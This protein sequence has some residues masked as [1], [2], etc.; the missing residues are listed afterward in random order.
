MKQTLSDSTSLVM[1]VRPSPSEFTVPENI[2]RRLLVAANSYRLDEA[3]EL[4]TEAARTDRGRSALAYKDVLPAVLQLSRLLSSSSSVHPHLIFSTLR[5]LRNLCAGEIVNQNSF[6]REN[7]VEVVSIASSYVDL[8]SNSD[9]SFVRVGLQVFGNVSLGGE[10]HRTAVWDWHF[11]AVFLDIARIHKVEVF[12]PLCMVIYNC[13]KGRH[14]RIRELSGVQGLPI[15]I[16]IVRTASTV[17][18]QED[19]FKLLLSIICFEESHFLSLFSE[20]RLVENAGNFKYGDN[21]FT[22]EQAF[23]L[24]TVAECL[25]KKMTEIS[26]SNEFANCVLGIL[27]VAVGVLDCVSKEKFGLP[28]GSAAIDVLGYSLTTLRDICARDEML[29]SEKDS[30]AGVIESLLSAGLV[31][32]ML[33]LLRNLEPPAI[34]KKSI[35]QVESCENRK[36]Y[37]SSNSLKVCPYKGFRRD[38]V[39]VIGNCLYRREHVQDEIRQNNGIP[40]LLQ[41]CVTDEDNPFLREWGIWMVRNLLAGNAENQRE[42]AELKVQGS[43]DLPEFAALGL[44]VVVDQSGRPKLVNVSA[45]EKISGS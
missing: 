8:G 17:G 33:D 44:Q 40:L 31:E 14:E 42:V 27:K 12:D 18:F 29:S 41:Q 2:L 32:L 26:V 19:W 4:L 9:Y 5:L 11:P 36:G 39:G 16:E 34:I 43:V 38:I 15:L 24:S 37:M 35:K 23:L 45:D 28:T 10:E 22:M 1:E 21:H 13:C 3:L 30:S 7:G 25:N 6:V 20:L